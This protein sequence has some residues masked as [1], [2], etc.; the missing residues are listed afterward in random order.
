MRIPSEN[1][2]LGIGEIGHDAASSLNPIEDRHANVH[3][4]H[5]WLESLD[6]CNGFIAI[7]G[8]SH[9]LYVWGAAKDQ[10]QSVPHQFVIVNNANTNETV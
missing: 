9:H 8:F 4:N 2:D 10:T 7:L 3:E 6:H 1:D 5:I